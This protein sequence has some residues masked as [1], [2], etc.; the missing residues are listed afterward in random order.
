M[1][2]DM[3]P[4]TTISFDG[5]PITTGRAFKFEPDIENQNKINNDKI[6]TFEMQ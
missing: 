2:E 6:S 4:G 5:S 1:K 3:E